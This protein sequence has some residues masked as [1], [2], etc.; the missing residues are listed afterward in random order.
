MHWYQVAA[1]RGD[2]VASD[3]LVGEAGLYA[4]GLGVS[5][6]LARAKALYEQA[7]ALGNVTAQAALADLADQVSQD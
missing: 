3:G 2:H 4:R 5:Q 7:A 1:E 6:D